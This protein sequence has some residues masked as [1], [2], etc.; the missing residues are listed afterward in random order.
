MCTIIARCHS[1]FHKNF[2]NLY[3]DVDRRFTDSFRFCLYLSRKPVLSSKIKP[4]VD[5][6]C[7]TIHVSDVHE[8]ELQLLSMSDD[9]DENV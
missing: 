7:F 8:Q 4:A 9:L 1:F 5:R 3:P 2:V 6:R